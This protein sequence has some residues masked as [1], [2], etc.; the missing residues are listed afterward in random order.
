MELKSINYTLQT[1][2]NILSAVSN[3]SNE[4]LNKIP[5]GFNN[6][7]IW[8]MGHLLVTQQLLHYK[9]SNTPLIISEDLVAQFKKG[10]K[11]QP[12]YSDELITTIKTQ[13]TSVYESINEDYNNHKLDNYKEY[14][15]SYNVILTSIEDAI[16]F[17]S[18]HEALH[19]G[20]IMALKRAIVK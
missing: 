20:Y 19:F 2:K 9:N 5:N 4:E 10:S 18:V 17:N 14:A 6:N 13:F 7:I 3:L 11:A 8:N 1:R 16:I 12:N 15:T